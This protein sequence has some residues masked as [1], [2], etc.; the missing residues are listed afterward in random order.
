MTQ[1]SKLQEGNIL[2]ET[3]YY[4]VEKIAGDKVQVANTAGTS[5]V[6]EKGYVESCIETADQYTKEE[7]ISGTELINIVLANARVAMTIYFQKQDTKKKVKDFKAELTAR[8]EQLKADFMD[9]GAVA[10]EE[11]LQNPVTK[12]IPGEMREMKGYFIGTQDERGRLQFMDMELDSRGQKN[13][14]K[15]VDSRTIQYVIVN[16]VKYTLKK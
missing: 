3:Q 8:A 9:K 1:F 6:L 13:V 15:G 2:S 16:N 14:P 11:A 7:K 5:I 12:V 4:T 10:L